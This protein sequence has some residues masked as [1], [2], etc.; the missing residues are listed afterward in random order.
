MPLQHIDLCTGRREAHGRHGAAHALLFI[1]TELPALF[2]GLLP[3]LLTVVLGAGGLLRRRRPD[4]IV[5]SIYLGRLGCALIAEARFVVLQRTAIHR[6]APV[7]L[8]VGADI[9]HG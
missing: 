4:L 2:G 8:L 6:G 5:L 3:P 9:A 7:P 1:M